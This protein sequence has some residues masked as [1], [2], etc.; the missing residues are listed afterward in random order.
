MSAS[1]VCRPQK[2]SYN[3]VMI[4]I[5]D[6]EM[7]NLRSVS[8]SLEAVGGQCQITRDPAV[9][10]TA[11]KLVVPGVGAFRDCMGALKKFEL[12]EPIRDFIASGRP[13]LGICL[14]M[15]ILMETSEEG[16]S[17]EGL[18]IF[19]GK[20]V[21]F[22]PALK[23]KVPHMGWNDIEAKTKNKIFQ[24]LPEKSFVYFVHSYYIAPKKKGL[25]AAT[26]HYGVEFTSV[27]AKDNVYAVQFHPEK[28]QQ[29][30]LKLLQNFV[31][32]K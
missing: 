21:R 15:Q 12:L 4:A 13:Y 27:L 11:E 8:K 19:P 26:T 9:V 20:V 10:A 16:G 18:G 2:V 17:H 3:T 22:D 32:L 30:G 14:G 31:E 5:L 24:G 29:V 25:T 6:Y 28:S 23:L 7:G 1:R